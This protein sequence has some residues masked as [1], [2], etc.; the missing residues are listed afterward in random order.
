MGK[1]INFTV[2]LAWIYVVCILFVMCICV[3]LAK[4]RVAR[5]DIPSRNRFTR[6]ELIGIWFLWVCAVAWILA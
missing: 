4:R 2:I 3:P 1:L 6:N 5:G